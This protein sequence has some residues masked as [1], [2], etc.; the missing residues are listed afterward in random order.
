MVRSIKTY[1]ISSVIEYLQVIKDFDEVHISQ[2]MYRGVKNSQYP[3]IPTLFRL[4]IPPFTDW[5]TYEKY[6]L[7]SF[8]NEGA[9]HFNQVVNDDMDLM[10][11]AQ[12]HGLPTR[13][14]DWTIKPLVALFF[15]TEGKSS[16]PNDAAVWCF[17]FPSTNNCWGEAT[18]MDIKKDL[19][20]I[21]SEY[22]GESPIIFP[23]HISPRI[24]SQGGCFTVHD[25]PK[26]ESGFIPLEKDEDFF[27]CLEKIVISSADKL[28]I[29]NELFDLGISYSYVFPDLDGIAKKLIFE[30]DTT[31]VRNSNF[32]QIKRLFEMK[33]DE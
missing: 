13:L 26:N 30:S 14:L 6:L 9:P 15:A 24:V 7:D 23:K 19:F 4:N 31:K 33:S 32:E 20:R 22:K 10:V 5:R 18:R 1:R 11:I 27:G 2:W 16:E 21:C 12:H 17:G 28:N 8:K 29:Q 3:L 25:F